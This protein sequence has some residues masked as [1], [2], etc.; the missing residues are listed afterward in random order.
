MPQ[1]NASFLSSEMYAAIAG[2]L[3][4]FLLTVLWQYFVDR[5]NKTKLTYSKKIESPL[6]IPKNELKEKLRIYYEH[7]EIKDIF[8]ARL[9]IK[10]TGQKTVKKQIFRCEFDKDAKSIDRKFPL[11]ITNPEKEILVEKISDESQNGYQPNVF[12][13]QVEALAPEQSIQIDFLFDGNKK[14]FNISFRPNQIDEVKF[15]E[16]ALSS[17]PNLENYIWQFGLSII[18][19]IFLLI[20]ATILNATGVI[21]VIAAIPFLYFALVS[22]RKLLPLLL[23]AITKDEGLDYLIETGNESHVVIGSGTIVVRPEESGS[24]EESSKPLSA[25]VIGDGRIDI[26]SG[27]KAVAKKSTA[28]S[29]NRKKEI[30]TQN[31]KRKIK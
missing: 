20:T 2:V 23:E 21:G 10:N 16:G 17:D 6:S 26:S 29:R 1:N 13:Y 27:K 12:R 8:Y 19:M 28:I 4:T 30:K 7:D 9:T 22:F 3:I 31:K 24:D 11:V 14:D 15:L 5:R 18:I 25:T